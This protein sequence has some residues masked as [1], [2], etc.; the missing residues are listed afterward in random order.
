[1][2]QG[3]T[4]L[5]GRA[6]VGSWFAVL[7]AVLVALAFVGGAAAYTAHVDPGSTTEQVERTHWTA[8]GTYHHAAE[9]TRENPVFPVGS[10]LSNRSTYYTGVSPELDSEYVLTYTG[11][12]AASAAVDLNASLVIQSSSDETVYWTDRTELDTT[13]VDSLAPG[14][15]TRLGF[16]L[17]ATQVAE[18]RSAI[19]SALGDTQGE[20]ETFVAVD[21]TVAGAVDGG[22]ADLSFTHRLPV[23]VDGGSYAVGPETAGSEPMT[24]T[25]TVSTPREHG[26]FWSL[27]GPLLFLVGAGG[28]AGLALGRRRDAFSLPAAERDL[29][30]YRDDR[31]E[32]DEWIVRARLSP[33]FEDRTR[34]EAESLADVVDF[35]IDAGTGVVED[36]GSGRFYAVTEELAVVYEPPKLARKP[37]AGDGDDADDNGILADVRGDSVSSDENVSSGE[38]GSDAVD[39][40][41]EGGS[42]GSED[43][44]PAATVEAVD[45]PTDDASRE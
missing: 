42:G 13:S 22:S 36:P 28:L 4:K 12:D 21:V 33:T 27:G 38:A 43:A 5:R 34:A 40:T 7:A 26:P 14:E 20:I 16:T 17:N 10:T 35:A 30:A 2:T 44:D 3:R 1:M 18:R 31:A 15:S 8:D 32:F 6:I 11:Q 23:S 45:E 9:V 39:A 37:T 24:T 25:R 29:L 19:Q 41:N